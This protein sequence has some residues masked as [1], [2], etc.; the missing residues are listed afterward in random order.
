MPVA[1]S[2]LFVQAHAEDDKIVDMFREDSVA[3]PASSIGRTTPL[4]RM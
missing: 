2:S 4:V 1:L 3:M